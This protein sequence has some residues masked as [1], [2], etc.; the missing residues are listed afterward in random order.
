M[1]VCV[2]DQHRINSRGITQFTPKGISISVFMFSKSH[3]PVLSWALY[4]LANTIFFFNILSVHF[5]L[6]VVND[7]GGSDADY[8]YPN[9]AAMF[10]VLHRAPILGNISDQTRRRK[11][12]L[13]LT[14]VW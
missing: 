10:F 13:I 5:A 2:N 4:D 1:A 12:F 11:P 9:A 3:V 7:M 14:T 8:G 6:W